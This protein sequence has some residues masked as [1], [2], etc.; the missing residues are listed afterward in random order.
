MKQQRPAAM[1]GLAFK[2]WAHELGL[3]SSDVAA[4]TGRSR[5][6]IEDVYQGRTPVQ[7]GMVAALSQ[8]Q[9]EL[10]QA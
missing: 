9:M 6:T 5:R 3:N 10:A 8:Y 7:P 2:G 1:P 4:L